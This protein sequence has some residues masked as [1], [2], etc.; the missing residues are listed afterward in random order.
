MEFIQELSTNEHEIR[1]IAAAIVRVARC[2]QA[3]ADKVDGR[4][5]SQAGRKRRFAPEIDALNEFVKG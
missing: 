1:F 3:R 5:S 4:D 2:D